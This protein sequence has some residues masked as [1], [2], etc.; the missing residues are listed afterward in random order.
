MKAQTS[1]EIVRY[2]IEKFVTEEY[3][4]G[5][6]FTL[7]SWISSFVMSVGVFLSFTL[8]IVLVD[9][10]TGRLAAK[11]RGEAVQSHK[12]RNTVRKYILYMLG[13]LISELFVRTFSLP[14]PLTYMVAGV[15]A[16]TEIKSI[17]ENIETVTGV[18][19]WSYIG[20]KLTR[21]ILRR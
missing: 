3:W 20:E 14:I 5:A 12:Y 15:I 8:T 21:L 9:L 16:L 1:K 10:Y 13:I 18:R 11:H 2:N 19:L 7:L 4:I 6:G 17:F